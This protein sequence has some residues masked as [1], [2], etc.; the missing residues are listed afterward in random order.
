VN[1]FYLGTPEVHRKLKLL[2][3]LLNLQLA[4][5]TERQTTAIIGAQREKWRASL[6]QTIGFYEQCFE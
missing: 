5:G 4:G 2:N 6:G 3:G 1:P